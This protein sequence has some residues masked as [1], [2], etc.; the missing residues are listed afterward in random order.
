MKGDCQCIDGVWKC[1][2]CWNR[3]TSGRKK[4]K[5]VRNID[6]SMLIGYMAGLGEGFP[7]AI[8]ALNLLCEA[9]KD[10]RFDST[11]HAQADTDPLPFEPS[12]YEL[13]D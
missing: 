7:E 4:Q 10:G 13:E 11:A 2:S 1:N 6:G 9:I 3:I 5:G 12:K 8:D